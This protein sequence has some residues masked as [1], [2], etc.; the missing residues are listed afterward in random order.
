MKSIK[1]TAALA[2]TALVLVAT[3]VLSLVTYSKAQTALTGTL[4]ELLM[5]K[6][7][8]TADLI[9]AQLDS[10]LRIAAG[11][12]RNFDGNASG[13]SQQAYLRREASENSLLYIGMMQSDGTLILPN[14]QAIDASQQPYYTALVAGERTITTPFMSAAD[15]N[16]VVAVAVPIAANNY[17]GLV[18]FLPG[19]ALGTTIADV[20]FGET[21]YAYMLDG[22]ATTIAHPNYDLVLQRDNDLENVKNDASL[23]EL[24]TIQKEM[25]QGKAGAGRYDYNGTDR[26]LGYAPIP[27]TNWS[28]AFAAE[29]SEVLNRITS[30]RQFVIVFFLGVL[31]VAIISAS[32]LGGALANPINQVAKLAKT[33]ADY[34]LTVSV[35]PQLLRRKDEV[36]QL[37]NSFAATVTMLQGSIGTM[38]SFAQR[39]AAASAQLNENAQ[40][41][42]ADVEEATASTEE[43]AA[44]METISASAEEVTASSQDMAASLN[45]LATEAGGAQIKTEEVKQRAQALSTDAKKASE[46]SSRVY[47]EIKEQVTT[48]IERMQV[49]ERINDLTQTISTIAAQTNLLSLNAAIE[50]ARA[51][52]AGRG[53][54]VVADEVRK[55]AAHS[56]EAVA[57]ISDLTEEVGDA[58]EQLVAAANRVLGFIN[59]TVNKDY[60]AIVAVGEQYQTDAVSLSEATTTASSMSQEVLSMVQEVNQAI[61][62]IAATVTESAAGANQISA[63]AIQ[64][65]QAVN[66]VSE[67][68]SKMSAASQELL[69]LV[70]KFKLT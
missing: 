8:D 19:Q 16:M 65:A 13:V 40:T 58:S 39:L 17:I 4:H 5:S 6:A 54:A 15:D 26:M 41:V 64:S 42:A 27:G 68:A 23:Q 22:E 20:D 45:Q 9:A 57:N 11:I 43:I 1:Q 14:G 33:I 56:G 59:D 49:V 37:A 52:E 35:P 10:W 48:A 7:E 2:I 31:V 32:L 55:L 46:T 67:L 60:E 62:S 47:A 12:A 29:T 53:F 63:G 3:L 21:G 18:G 28:L 30:I 69:Q 61:E 51:G 66:E 70:A 50:A 44:G 24:V 25:V 36:G 34:D 38:N